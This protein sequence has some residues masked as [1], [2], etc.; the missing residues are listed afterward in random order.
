MRYF[1]IYSAVAF[2]GLLV[3]AFLKALMPADIVFK[4]VI[5]IVS[6]IFHYSFL[7]YFF[8]KVFHQKISRFI[9]MLVFFSSMPFILFLATKNIIDR[10]GF[11]SFSV[12][13]FCLVI[14]CILYYYQLFSS[15]PKRQ[16]LN[17][18]SFWITSGIFFSMGITIPLH[19]IFKYLESSLD[20]EIFE[21]LRGIG[22]F[23][24][25]VMHL[26]FTKAYL[27]SMTPAK[28]L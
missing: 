7:S 27:C 14:F 22:F 25:G 21:G 9:F 16:L 2:S 23:A 26:F 17:E 28:T 8:N 11:E 20:H 1:F 15:S 24:Y 5:T 3:I 19:I 12:V 6:V 18:P 4:M 10:R 13:N